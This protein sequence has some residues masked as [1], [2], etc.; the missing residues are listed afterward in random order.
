MNR[1]AWRAS[2]LA[3]SAAEQRPVKARLHSRREERKRSMG[4]SV[5]DE[6]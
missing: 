3:G 4:M 1:R 6:E 2:S 5:G